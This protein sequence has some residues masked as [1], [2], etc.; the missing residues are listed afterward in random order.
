MLK[1][2]TRAINGDSRAKG[3]GVVKLINAL[4]NIVGSVLCLIGFAICTD[5]ALER[6][7]MEMKKK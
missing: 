5:E 2:S 7:Q 3:E 6:F 4:R 1:N